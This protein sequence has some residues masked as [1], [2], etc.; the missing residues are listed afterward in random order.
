MQITRKELYDLVWSEPMT[1][2]AKRFGLSDNG[3]RKHCKSMG[4]PTPPV[5]Y[6]IK[7]EHGKPVRIIPLPEDYE[8]KKTNVNLKE[9][10][11]TQLP[12][13][14]IDLGL[15]PEINRQEQIEQEIKLAD[16]SVFVVPEVLYAKDPL[17]IDTKEKHREDMIPWSQRKSPYTSKI[18]ECL[19]VYVG[20]KSIDRSLCIFSTII[21]A[22]RFRG[23]NIKIIKENEY[24]SSTYAVVK[25]EKIKIEIKERKKQKE[26]S[27]GARYLE[28]CGEL[29]FNI[30]YNWYRKFT[31]K[32]TTHTRL[33]DKIISI[34]AKLEVIAEEIKEERIA[35]EERKIRQ[36]EEERIRK[37]KEAKEREER[38]KFETKRQK[39]L[40]EFKT[41]FNMAE[42]LRKANMLRQYIA[43]YEE[44][45]RA[46]NAM[47][48]DVAKKLEWARKKADWLDPFIDLEDEYLNED[49]KAPR[50]EPVKDESSTRHSSTTE[51]ERYNFWTR[52]YRWFNKKR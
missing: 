52:P 8:G 39:E 29:N 13:E 42:R 9:V 47:D 27:K 48:D 44:Y 43:D 4:I 14:I 11:Q 33:E 20:E 38:E 16:P 34:I 1:A 40:K 28:Y 23:H 35:E 7:L 49:D 22:L 15:E 5:G 26:D 32:D 45:L 12:D 50:S 18:K 51:S 2:L 10:D 21:K 3:L 31:Y 30:H 25:D 37:E 46:S 17:I 19:N 36:A 24:N 6:W 41:M